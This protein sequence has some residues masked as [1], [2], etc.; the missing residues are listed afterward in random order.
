MEESRAKEIAYDYVKKNLHDT[1]LIEVRYGLD[2][3]YEYLNSED[4]TCSAYLIE[5][6]FVSQEQADINCKFRETWIAY[7]HVDYNEH[8]DSEWAG[9]CASHGRA[10]IY[11][12]AETEYPWQQPDGK[13]R[14]LSAAEKLAARK[15]RRKT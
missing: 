9:S 12:D 11:I 13:N 7:F 15:K 8:P 4:G 3:A 2:S 5:M 10:S 14:K 1:P 6:I